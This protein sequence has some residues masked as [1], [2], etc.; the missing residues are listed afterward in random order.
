MSFTNNKTTNWLIGGLI[1]MNL[2]L[3]TILFLNRPKEGMPF[4]DRHNDKME[5]LQ[6]E[7][8]LTDEQAAKFKELRKEHFTA[9]R[10]QFRK[11]RTLKKEMIEAL[12]Q[13]TPDTVNARLISIEI[14]NQHTVMDEMLI[15]HFMKLQAECNPEQRQKLGRVFQRF[16]KHRKGPRNGS[17]KERR[18]K[19][20]KEEN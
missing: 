17:M 18:K 8:D 4:E 20:F 14:G 5:W 16:T 11:I 13:E 2:V 10:E 3:L 12:A 9:T 6:K 19:R 7:L 15:D 1:L